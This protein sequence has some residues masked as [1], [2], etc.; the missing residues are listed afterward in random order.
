MHGVYLLI[1]DTI[2]IILLIFCY[3]LIIIFSSFI[4]VLH[5]TSDT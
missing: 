1:L 2:T 5:E 4:S 3:H